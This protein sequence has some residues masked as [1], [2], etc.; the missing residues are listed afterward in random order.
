MS[1]DNRLP[2]SE[3]LGGNEYRAKR[4]LFT[5]YDKAVEQ[6]LGNT[7]DLQ[8]PITGDTSNFRLAYTQKGPPKIYLPEP[9]HDMMAVYFLWSKINANPLAWLDESLML[10]TFR[11]RFKPDI[12]EVRDDGFKEMPYAHYFGAR[13]PI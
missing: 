1:I 12:I 8:I 13:L 9:S 11:M 10:K 2:F 6:I 4:D 3:T 5:L 7:S